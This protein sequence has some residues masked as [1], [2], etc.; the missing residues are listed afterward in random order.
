MILL[1]E[2]LKTK[3]FECPVY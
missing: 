1:Q 2:D 3:S